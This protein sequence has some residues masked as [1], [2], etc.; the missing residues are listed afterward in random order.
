MW[1]HSAKLLAFL[2]WCYV[3]ISGGSAFAFPIATTGDGFKV[4]AS[5]TDDIIAEYLGN[6]A[7]YSN[8]LYLDNGDGT[9][10][11]V[12]NNHSSSVGSTMNLGSFAI[13]TELIFVLHVNDTGYDYYTG[14]ADRNP[15]N[16][17]HARVQSNWQP[18][19]TLVSFEDLYNGPFDFNDLSFSFKNTIGND[20]PLVPEP[21]TAIL[22]GVSIVCLAWYRRTRKI[23]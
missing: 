10:T 13:G 2:I 12:F 16:N 19:T 22:L 21:S 9:M 14:P 17:A 4:F 5:S 7:A 8:D 1:T 18:D 20:V 3:L 6:S 23:A 11:F 15:D